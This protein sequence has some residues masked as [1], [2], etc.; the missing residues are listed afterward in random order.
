MLKIS[1]YLAIRKGWE[2]WR[3][4][5]SYG[6]FT[7]LFFRILQSLMEADVAML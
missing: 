5:D 4:D 7:P 2:N 1:V 6:E 3:G